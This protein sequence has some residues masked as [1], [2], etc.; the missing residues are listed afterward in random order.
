VV[1]VASDIKRYTGSEFYLPPLVEKLNSI[2]IRDEDIEI[3]VVLG[4]YRKQRTDEHKKIVG[5]LHELIRVIDHDCDD[6]DGLVSLERTRGSIDVEVNRRVVEAER[7]II[8]GTIGFHYFAGFGGGRKS[9]LPGVAS[10][11]SCMAS[12]FAVLNP[13][14][15]SGKTLRRQPAT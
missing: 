12:H 3:L 14:E 1:I 10:R 13:S 8:T 9:I 11:R 15:G 2:G 6:R 4:I 7:L 5:P